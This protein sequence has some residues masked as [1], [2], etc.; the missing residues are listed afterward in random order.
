MFVEHIKSMSQLGYGYSRSEL[1][2]Q[3]SNYAVFLGK[4]D[5]EHPLSDRW[6]RSFMDR[7]PELKRVKPRSLVNYCAQA[8]CKENVSAYFSNLQST[9]LKNDLL[10]KPEHIYNVNEIGVQTEHS[11]PYIICADSSIPA[12]TSSR[13]CI[14]TI[15][16][17]CNAIG[18]Q[19]PP[20]F[21][22]KGKGMRSELLEG[23]SPGT[24]G[25]VTETG[26]S[27]SDVFLKYLDTHFLKFVQ[28]PSEDHPLLLIFDGHKSH[29]TI[30][31][32]DWAKEHN[33]S[34]FV[35]PGHTSHVL[36]PLDVGCYNAQCQ[37][38]EG[39]PCLKDH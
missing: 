24:Q 11:P 18:S 20:Y 21:V 4:R 25:T 22:F 31:V 34:L 15:L 27:N 8:T 6:Y 16:G 14:T 13:S 7:W 37:V 29:I 2:D 39:K 23:S 35:L 36:E 3:A 9:L 33:V 1:D 30:P 12:I 38:F 10:D 19:M 5:Q 26:W 28:R 32:I 17:C